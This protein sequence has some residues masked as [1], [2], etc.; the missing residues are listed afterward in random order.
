[1]RYENIIDTITV[2]PCVGA[3]EY[4][5]NKE[6]F[7]DYDT[8]VEI[9]H[10]ASVAHPKSAIPIC[11]HEMVDRADLILCCIERGKGGIWRMP[12]Y[13]I[14]QEKA[15]INLAYDEALRKIS[16]IYSEII[17][18]AMILYYNE[19]ITFET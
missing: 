19:A 15:V 10:T 2:P 6:S 16:N 13:V 4:R 1:V 17:A 8:D 3:A 9:F 5:N 18:N 7:H 14:K 11:H 12:H